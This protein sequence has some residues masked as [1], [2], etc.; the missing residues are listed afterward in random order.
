[1]IDEVDC[2]SSDQLESDDL[3]TKY[4]VIVNKT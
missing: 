4:K 1:M 2:K 3:Y